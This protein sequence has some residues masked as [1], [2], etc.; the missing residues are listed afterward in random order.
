NA[1]SLL[2][3][4]NLRGWVKEALEGLIN[5]PVQFEE[6]MKILMVTDDL[7]LPAELAESFREMIEKLDLFAIYKASPEVVAIAVRVIASQLLYMGDDAFHQRFEKDLL[8]IVLQE[9]GQTNVKEP[10]APTSD[11]RQKTGEVI[12]EIA[13]RAVFGGSS[14]PGGS[15]STEGLL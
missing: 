15:V 13:L 3:P 1:V 8:Q 5:N 6:W 4:A 12:L 2:S 11:Y 7:P 14:G 9:N 10:E